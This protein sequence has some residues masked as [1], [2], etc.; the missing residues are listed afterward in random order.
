MPRYLI[1]Q[2]ISQ[3]YLQGKDR[4][5]LDQLKIRKD[6]HTTKIHTVEYPEAYPL[7]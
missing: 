5:S 7:P 1:S 4:V 3:E 6:R 2:T